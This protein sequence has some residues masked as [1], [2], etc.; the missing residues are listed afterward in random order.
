[1]ANNQDSSISFVSLDDF[2]NNMDLERM[3][4]KEIAL[5]L[6]T[7]MDISPY[8]WLMLLIEVKKRVSLSDTEKYKEVYNLFKRGSTDFSQTAKDFLYYYYTTLAKK[9]WMNWNEDNPYWDV[10]NKYKDQL[11]VPYQTYYFARTSNEA[12]K[13][14]AT[15][16]DVNQMIEY[17]SNNYAEFKTLNKDV[18]V[19]LVYTFVFKFFIKI[20]IKAFELNKDK[21]KKDDLVVINEPEFCVTLLEEIQSQLLNKHIA[22]GVLIDIKTKNQIDVKRNLDDFMQAIEL[23]FYEKNTVAIEKEWLKP[24]HHVK[25]YDKEGKEIKTNNTKLMN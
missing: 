25:V 19:N 1:M 18:Q 13:T 21:E 20:Q 4:A 8:T 15:F 12:L 9:E 3:S 17:M 16:L 6:S 22:D 11:H 2:I 5:L 7:N 14:I 23:W 24:N 10:I